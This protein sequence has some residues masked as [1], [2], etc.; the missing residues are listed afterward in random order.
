MSVTPVGPD[1]LVGAGRFEWRAMA[2]AIEVNQ[3]PDA[4]PSAAGRASRKRSP[5]SPPRRGSSPVS[6][7]G[8][9][10][11]R[12]IVE[13]P[14]RPG[15]LGDAPHPHEKRTLRFSSHCAPPRVPAS[16]LGTKAAGCRPRT[17]GGRGRARGGERQRDDLCRH[18][19]RAPE[20]RAGLEKGL[21]GRQFH[22]VQP[23]ETPREPLG[24]GSA[25]PASPRSWLGRSA[26]AVP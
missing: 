10:H 9:Q 20:G 6:E 13:K 23:L 26:R 18:A 25:R 11:L 16:R 3:P 12:P 1:G 19:L 5:P 8:L 15:F 14:S 2:R 24:P 21:E 22:L 17:V 7:R 4:H